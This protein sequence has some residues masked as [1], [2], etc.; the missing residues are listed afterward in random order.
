MEFVVEEMLRQR[1]SGRAI[2]LISTELEELF[3]ICD[4]IVVMFHGEI[5]GELPPDRARLDELGLL[6]A[7]N[8]EQAALAG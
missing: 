6:M 5:L 4:R 1:D 3:A 2:L 7:G 8:K